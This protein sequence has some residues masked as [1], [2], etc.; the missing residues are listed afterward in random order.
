MLVNS[1][2]YLP[3]P[4]DRGSKKEWKFISD[5]RLSQFL[6]RNGKIEK[7]RLVQLLQDVV[8]SGEIE[9]HSAKTC[10]PCDKIESL[11]SERDGLPT[12]ILS[13]DKNE[14]LGILTP[15]DLL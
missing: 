13:L 11:L 6:R 10:G 2:S 9:L 7:D 15:F 4:I 5:F 12:L 14:L 1:F 3:V 8:N